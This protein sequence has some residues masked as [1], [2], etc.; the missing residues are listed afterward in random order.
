MMNATALRALGI[1]GGEQLV[2]LMTRIR[3]GDAA[4][5]DDLFQMERAASAL[6]MAAPPA[7]PPTDLRRRVLSRVAV[8]GYYFLHERDSE[9]ELTRYAGAY[10]RQLFIDT[11]GKSE[12]RLIRVSSGTPPGALAELAGA[13]FYLISGDLHVDG[14]SLEFGDYFHAGGPPLPGKTGQGCVLFTVVTAGSRAP[15]GTSRSRV[16]VRP[17][18]GEWVEV[19]PGVTTK[20]LGSDPDRRVEMR[21]V[22]MEPGASWKSH[23]HD[24]PEEVF[25][26]RGGWRCLGTNLHPGDFHR[27]GVGTE[28]ETT[29]T[30]PGCK[31][32]VVKHL[33]AKM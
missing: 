28:H 13:D 26:I 22:R 5:E 2:R 12:T 7:S 4:L 33:T 10:V 32:I 18:E 30:V 21:L 16:T 25:V 17:I 8:D 31:L 1:L 3:E 27:A 11:L 23:R 19:E 20:M 29:S 24:G 9:W 15:R 6:A 14:A